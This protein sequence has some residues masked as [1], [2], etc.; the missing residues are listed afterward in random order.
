MSESHLRQMRVF[1][2]NP[3]SV[4]D[5]FSSEFERGYLETL[6]QL[7][8]T[9]R[10]KANKVY[11]EYIQD[12]HHIHMNATIWT[13]LTGFCMHLGKESKA[14][15]DETEKGW[16]IQYIDRD[17][18]VLARQAQNEQRQRFEL[19]EEE[20]RKREILA[21]V[22]AAE[23]RKRGEN[24][25]ADDEEEVD[26]TLNREDHDQKIAVTLGAPATS[27]SVGLKKRPRAVLGFAESDDEE[28]APSAKKND[29]GGANGN[30]N[31]NGNDSANVKSAG[32]ET[33]VGGGI[34]SASLAGRVL[35][36]AGR[37]V[38][39]GSNAGGGVLAQMMLEEERRKA[40]Q[41]SQH[42]SSQAAQT[43]TQAQT[44]SQKSAS[45]A[46]STSSKAL[47]VEKEP[48]KASRGSW[49]YKNIVVKVVNK[50]VARGRIYKL[51][52]RVVRL[53]GR[54]YEEAEVDI[55]GEVYTLHYKDLETTLPKVGHPLL[56]LS[57]PAKGL[58]GELLRI[59]EDKFN[60]DVRITQR[61][62]SLT[63][64]E[65]RGMEYDHVCKY[66]P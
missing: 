48:T 66:S 14:I 19:D 55:E 23:E 49:L 50:E 28:E 62:N 2:E 41:M 38:P 57:G 58:E 59:H 11:Q 22:H 37:V 44:Q 18:K 42:A 30:G 3:N 16:F 63:G 13:T 54:D 17:P 15:V 7:H 20:R 32:T 51:K 35:T 1:A 24:G 6:N 65:L 39:L 34:T 29:T 9:K 25:G 60:C 61:G 5:E 45:E 10:V 40:K 52:G 27:L 36:S 64:E 47:T 56:V 8:G 21:Q 4:L 53:L 46:V 31:G 26:N 12:K 43:Q 33:G